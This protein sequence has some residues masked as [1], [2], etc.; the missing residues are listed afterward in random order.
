MAPFLLMSRVRGEF[1]L[2]LLLQLR[3]K[4]CTKRERIADVRQKKAAPIGRETFRNGFLV[5]KTLQQ[6]SRLASS[7]SQ[8]TL[9]LSFLCPLSESRQ[10]PH[11]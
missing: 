4:V 1:L 2:N 7:H 10:S 11:Q 8:V 5:I 3:K 9:K 6:P